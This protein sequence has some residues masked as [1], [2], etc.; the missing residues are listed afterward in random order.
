MRER[1]TGSPETRKEQGEIEPTMN[2]AMRA[3]MLHIERRF[4]FW[5]EGDRRLEMLRSIYHNLLPHYK[6]PKGRLV[7]IES[8][9]INAFVTT[10]A[11]DVYFFAGFLETL[12]QY[13]K[14]QGFPMTEDQIAFIIAHEMGHLEQIHSGVVTEEDLTQKERASGLIERFT[15]LIKEEGRKQRR[16][17][18]E[19]DADR[20]A[21]TRMA[22]AGYN[23]RE[24]IKMMYLFRSLGDTWVAG[25]HPRSND[26]LREVQDLVESPD[27]VIPNTVKPPQL[28][29]IESYADTGETAIHPGTKLYSQE[30]PLEH[31]LDTR[32]SNIIDVVEIASV[33]LMYDVYAKA[34]RERR[35]ARVLREAGKLIALRNLYVAAYGVYT[36]LHKDQ[37]TRSCDFLERVL[38]R[39]IDTF[40]T[41]PRTITRYMDSKMEYHDQHDHSS[42][43]EQDNFLLEK[44]KQ[45]NSGKSGMLSKIKSITKTIK[46]WSGRNPG[47]HLDAVDKI[48]RICLA[49]EQV[50]RE[51]VSIDLDYLIENAQINT[52][53]QGEPTEMTVEQ[54]V[55]RA[56]TDATIFF[57]NLYMKMNNT[58]SP[59]Q[60]EDLTTKEGREKILHRLLL[61]FGVEQL[62]SSEPESGG[63]SGGLSRH[64]ANI[65]AG[66]S[67]V[68]D[69]ALG[70]GIHER[71]DALRSRIENRFTG[72][73]QESLSPEGATAIG[74]H[75]AGVFYFDEEPYDASSLDTLV[76]NLSIED[77]IRVARLLPRT[78]PSFA[79]S[80]SPLF[81][82][83]SG[84]DKLFFGVEELPGTVHERFIKLVLKRI[85]EEKIPA[86]TPEEE[87]DACIKNLL[88]GEEM[89]NIGDVARIIGRIDFSSP[90]IF[91][92]LERLYSAHKMRG[93]M[94]TSSLNRAILNRISECEKDRKAHDLLTIFINID[95]DLAG[96]YAEHVRYVPR[97]RLLSLEDRELFLATALAK[98]PGSGYCVDQKYCKEYG[99]AEIYPHR[100]QELIE[101]LGLPEGADLPEP[102]YETI[103]EEYLRLC[104][105]KRPDES[106][107]EAIKL[108]LRNGGDINSCTEAFREYKIATPGGSGT[109]KDTNH[110][111]H[112]SDNDLLEIA[113]YCVQ[114]GRPVKDVYM[115]ALAIVNGK[116]YFYHKIGRDGGFYYLEEKDGLTI[117]EPSWSTHGDLVGFCFDTTRVSLE[118]NL[119]N[120]LSYVSR[121]NIN[122]DYAN[123]LRVVNKV[124]DRII[125]KHYPD[126]GLEEQKI[127]LLEVAARQLVAKYRLSPSQ[128]VKH[129]LHRHFDP[130]PR[131][132]CNRN[133]LSPYPSYPPTIREQYAGL[134][135]P[136][137]PSIFE[138]KI[139][140]KIDHTGKSSLLND[141]F[142]ENGLLH[143]SHFTPGERAEMIAGLIRENTDYRDEMFMILEEHVLLEYGIVLREGKLKK[144]D[145]LDISRDDAKAIYEFYETAIPLALN[146]EIQEY[147]STRADHL[148]RE[149][150]GE[151]M[152]FDKELKRIC[153][154]YPI[155]SFARD[156]ALLALGDSERI[157]KPEQA[158]RIVSLLFQNNRTTR[159][160]DVLVQQRKIEWLNSQ[161]GGLDRLERKEYVLW[162]IGA[163][164]EAPVSARAFGGYNG[165]S[166]EGVPAAVFGL[167][168]EERREMFLRLLVGELGVFE[169]FTEDDKEQM[170]DFVEKIFNH[171]FPETSP[172]LDVSGRKLI[173]TAFKTALGAYT[174]YRRA[175]LFIRMV[176]KMHTTQTHTEAVDRGVGEQLKVLLESLG[177]VAI[178]VGQVL[179]EEMGID[180]NHLLPQDIRSSLQ[181]LKH[182]ADTFHRIASVQIL[183]SKGEFLK[184]NGILE[185]DRMIG[186]ASVKQVFTATAPD[187][188]T[189]IEKV[190]RPSIEKHIG[191][192]FV[193]MDKILQDL[194]RAGYDV[195]PNLSTR[196]RRLVDEEIDFKK[197]VQNQ[198]N[199]SKVLAE[200][201][202]KCHPEFPVNTPKV[203]GYSADHIRE[204]AVR[205]ITIGELFKLSDNGTT[206]A[207]LAE[208][209]RMPSEEIE[210]FRKL[211]PKVMDIKAQVVDCLLF[212]IFNQ[213]AFHSDPHD[214][215]IMV[216]AE[217]EL[218]FI[219]LGSFAK[220]DRGQISELKKMIVALFT[221]QSEGAIESLRSFAPNLSDEHV[222]SIGA[223]LHSPSDFVQKI[224]LI[225]GIL[226]TTETD[227]GFDKFLK[228]VTTAQYLFRDVD[229]R[230]NYSL[231]KHVLT[232]D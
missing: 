206:I 68:A 131:N 128:A 83:Y 40:D 174:P 197:E 218:S 106:L 85:N 169:P 225:A 137:D 107:K 222:E 188:A 97:Y 144:M 132:I 58:K 143:N 5:K 187:G 155:A 136:E 232:G 201:N 84:V 63:P 166:V 126:F 227:P 21:I 211:I 61:Q 176:E 190:R 113:A 119:K 103:S 124:K 111:Y 71:I 94:N 44:L 200:Y 52:K 127:S 93:I 221:G 53:G 172:S 47:M 51:D 177:P 216:S 41:D 133:E 204:E 110:P 165:R 151:V 79:M 212:Q 98:L 153:T 81:V 42:T 16:V 26:R 14:Q 18:L 162:L 88:E 96:T 194:Y 65:A 66:Y 160:G 1:N 138:R 19:Y 116:K 49:A 87:L 125:S 31:L 100:R 210:D 141:L 161:V 36:D 30:E 112:L 134:Y 17:N 91:E 152:G 12:E 158:Q 72:Y 37:Q 186:A 45:N 13:N 102:L 198:L 121:E 105:E 27:T 140:T 60:H 67:R 25:T 229:D 148:Y 28:L 192:D 145:G 122:S 69:G 56:T 184:G 231:Y 196:V 23:P 185:L 20:M 99:E 168:P 146:A 90:A 32:A 3:H 159:D 29:T 9:E 209:Y 62:L 181:K 64:T 228:T 86:M 214:G 203:L 15:D 207:R 50:A 154:I 156:S 39:D 202:E 142:T 182:E 46:S 92:T 219:D 34:D 48:N 164:K 217:G 89:R 104:K 118:E 95:S 2:P 170:D 189:V 55:H 230:L 54:I 75:L 101:K 22:Q 173:R 43:Q 180:G 109:E 220:M 183:A 135:N 108:I 117:E 224:N 175:Q 59:A 178:K 77:C 70:K 208:K 76:G 74:R 213:G 150:I 35:D 123:A 11:P 115:R 139:P 157:K 57:S 171:I 147:W 149:Y 38:R 195:P 82:K 8:P 78:L 226:M 114:I 163:Q 193:V 199:L 129:G 130:I 24:G 73:Y 215:N 179:S 80:A 223:V 191:E 10:D 7:G 205:G 4:G 6:I 167:A 120:I 33:A